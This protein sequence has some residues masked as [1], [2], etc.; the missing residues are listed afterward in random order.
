MKK[1]SKKNKQKQV[2]DTKYFKWG[3]TAFLV[4]VASMC[5]IFAIYN[6]GK[7]SA[8]I[9]Q[10]FKVL[11]PIIDG[12]VIA[13]LLNPIVRFF[14]VNLLEK[15]YIRHNLEITPGRKKRFRVFSIIITFL[16]VGMLLYAFFGTVLPQLY[17]SIESI[18]IHFP[19]YYNNVIRSL[20][21]FI[22]NSDYLAANDLHDLINT[23]SVEINDIFNQNILPNMKDILG[24]L[25]ATDILAKLSSGVASVVGAVF[26]LIIGLIISIYLLAAKEKYVG[27]VKKLIYSFLPREKANNVLVDIRFINMTFGGFIVGKIVD[28]IIIGILC[29][30]G[31]NILHTPY[32]VLVSVIVGITNIVPFF[33]PYLGAIPSAFLILIVDPKQCLIF[34]IFVLIL[35][36]IDGNIIGP[37]I[38]GNSI[39]VS[40]FWIIVAITIFGGFFGIPGMIVGVPLFACVYAF[41]RRYVN[42]RLIKNKLSISTYDYAN[43]KY[44]DEKNNLIMND[45]IKSAKENAEDKNSPQYARYIELNP[46]AATHHHREKHV[47]ETKN[48]SLVVKLFEYIKTIIANSIQ[49]IKKRATKSTND[50]NETVINESETNNES[51]ISE[52]IN[53]E[54]SSES[55]HNNA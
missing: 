22:S 5:F 36:Q 29:F 51:N 38:L 18:I 25:K 53:L 7:I 20:D 44:V 21:T 23:Y 35:Q 45:H 30:I 14:E 27:L 1:E 42:N 49:T 12:L 55:D 13:Y 34:L 40:S 31:L 10:V 41:V 16:L 8:G 4:I 54:A 39:G 28:S 17:S 52:D 48:K 33:G 11:T 26:N 43:I 47:D 24:E 9:K 2:I 46:S 37:A 50:Q 15:S 3:L 6:S 19:T 32:A